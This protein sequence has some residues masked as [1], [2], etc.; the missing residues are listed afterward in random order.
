MKTFAVALSLAALPGATAFTASRA[1][2]A[3]MKARAARRSA[4]SMEATLTPRAWEMQDISPDGTLVQ[5][6]E[7]QTRKTWKFNNIDKDRVQVTNNQTA[8]FAQSFGWRRER[9]LPTLTPRL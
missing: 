5:R 8:G 3:T 7:G 2:P 9:H 1:S 6:I 4:V